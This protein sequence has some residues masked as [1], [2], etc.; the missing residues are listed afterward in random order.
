MNSK[1]EDSIRDVEP[2][3]WLA[4]YARSTLYDTNVN[5]RILETA[6]DKS[7]LSILSNEYPLVSTKHDQRI[8]ESG[9]RQLIQVAPD[10]I[11]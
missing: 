1:S 9:A 11:L 3:I 4:Q 8:S 2:E 7:I 5:Q 6:S 10:R